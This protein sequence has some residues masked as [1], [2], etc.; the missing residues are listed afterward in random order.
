MRVLLV[1]DNDND[2]VLIRE[3]L[4]DA[5]AVVDLDRV[6]SGSDCLDFLRKQGAFSEAKIPDMILLDLNL[7]DMGG[8]DVLR[9]LVK[10]ESIQHIPVIVVS[11]SD[12]QYDV[13]RMY[14]LRCSSYVIKPSNFDEYVDVLR[15]VFAYWSNASVLPNP[16]GSGSRT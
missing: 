10:D 5:G 4:S 3:A 14:R 16:D 2:A 1:E 15:T 13:L 12:D 11:T 9:E 8:A 7:P 6:A